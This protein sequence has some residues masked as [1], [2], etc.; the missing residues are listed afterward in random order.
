MPC[1]SSSVPCRGVRVLRPPR[2]M[3]GGLR[4]EAADWRLGDKAPVLAGPPDALPG[5]LNY[6]GA[7]ASG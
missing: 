1:K 2:S 6:T 5:G 4:S 7:V 3:S